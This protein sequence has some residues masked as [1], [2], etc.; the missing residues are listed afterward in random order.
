MEPIKRRGKYSEGTIGLINKGNRC[1]ISSVLQNLKNISLLT[2]YLLK[3]YDIFD[4]YGF[5]RKYCELIANLVNQN[6]GRY[7]DPINFV[8][9]FIE[10]APMFTLGQQND[11]NF[12]ILYILSLIERETKNFVGIKPYYPINYCNFLSGLEEKQKYN[13]FR[14]KMKQ[15]RNSCIIDFF[16]GSQEKRYKCNNSNCNYINYTFQGISVLNLS[17]MSQ[18]NSPIGSLEEAINY[19]QKE[20]KHFDKKDFFCSKCGKK[21]ISTQTIIISLPKIFYH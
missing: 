15:K 5:T 6:V 16:Y 17:I 14:G 19:Y 9:K 20:Q 18:Y 10:V 11:S 1:Y 4:L 13:E 21:K 7:Y 12:C 8:H 3:N 2:T